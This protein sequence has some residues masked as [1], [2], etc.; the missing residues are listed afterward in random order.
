M[1]SIGKPPQKSLI[2]SRLTVDPQPLNRTL[3]K[4]PHYHLWLQ[5]WRGRDCSDILKSHQCF[6]LFPPKYRFCRL[7]CLK[8]MRWELLNTWSSQCAASCL[9]ASYNPCVAAR[10]FKKWYGVERDEYF[11][12]ILEN[13]PASRRVCVVVLDFNH[14]CISR[15]R[16]VFCV[17]VL[18]MVMFR[19]Q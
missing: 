2:R 15:H 16:I 17:C 4:R 13:N 10:D 18:Q 3:G 19:G 8:C 14:L 1:L 6:L 7:L 12:A 11:S 9:Q 5:R